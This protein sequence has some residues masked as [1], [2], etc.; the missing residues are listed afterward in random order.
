MRGLAWILLFF[1]ALPLFGAF[2]TVDCTGAPPPG[3]FTSVAAAL[4]TLDEKGPNTITVDGTCTGAVSIQ[5]R[6]RLTI[7][8]SPGARLQ[9]PGGTCCS[10]RARAGSFCA[11]SR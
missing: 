9:A 5:Y 2:A 4:A 6:D 11:T 7:A 8:G 10:C 1:F 3:S